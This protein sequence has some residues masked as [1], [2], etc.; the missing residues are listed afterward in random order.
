MDAQGAQTYLANIKVSQLEMLDS[1]S[2]KY[3]ITI[4]DFSPFSFLM[5][6]ALGLRCPQFLIRKGN[7]LSK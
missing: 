5:R 7:R 4:G 6:I 3:E 2:G 1:S